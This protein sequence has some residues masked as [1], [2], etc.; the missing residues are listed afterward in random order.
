MG[1]DFSQPQRQSIV[2]IWVMFFYALQQYGRALWPIILIWAFKFDEINKVYLVVGMLLV[3]ASIGVVSYLKYLNFTFFLDAENEEFI[4]TEG[5]FNKTKTAIQLRKIQQVNINQSFIQKLIGVYELDVDTAGSNK[6]EGA[7]KA[8]SHE[9]A[10]ELKSRL[11]ENDKLQRVVGTAETTLEETEQKLFEAAHPFIK[12]SF[13]SLLKVGITSNYGKSIALLVIFF[14]TIYEN[15]QNFGDES[16]I[17]KE[18]VGSY[19]DKNL[20]LQTILTSILLLF[21]VVLV[22]NVTRIVFKFYDYKITRQ[23]G[24]MLLSFG[25]LNT[26][27]TIIKPE[28]VQITTVTRNYFQKKMGI[29]ELKIKQAT[30]GEKEERK[31]IIE[32]PGCSETERDSILRLL[33][34]QIPERGQMLQ[35]NYRK[36]IFSVVLSIGLPL[37][38][39]LGIGYWLEPI[40]FEY[41]YVVPFY[42]VV[43]GLIQYFKFKNNR[44]FIHKNFIIKQSGAWDVSN[45][46]IEPSKIQAITTSQLFWHKKLNIG[47]IILHTAGGNI[48]FQLA[49]YSIVKQ[50]V[51]LWLYE[52]E[53]SDSNWM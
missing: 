24:S 46:I 16:N 38:G 23:K 28:K 29:L 44:L 47:S 40:I 14:S 4:I 34:H 18:K 52:I 35:P 8:I 1:T 43:I 20:V 19:I 48:E 37:L 31:S 10:L 36:L 3:F 53:T 11:L 7:I 26:K 42:V 45:D 21:G 25:L 33:F 32:I 30:G 5:V 22:V 51:N 39:F 41:S 13:L 27:S 2:G 6:K 15:F 50:Q 17:Y 9:L 12:I 49:N